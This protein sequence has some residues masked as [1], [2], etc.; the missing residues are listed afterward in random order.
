[1]LEN[2]IHSHDDLK[3]QGLRGLINLFVNKKQSLQ[4]LKND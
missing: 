4:K 1:M 2:N 3:S